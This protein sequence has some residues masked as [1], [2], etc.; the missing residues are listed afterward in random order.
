MTAAQALRAAAGVVA[1]APDAADPAREARLLLCW[2]AGW[3]AAATSAR[4]EEPLPEAAAAR[5]A[6]GAARRAAGA[7]LSHVTG[8][9]AFWEAS[10]RVTPDVLDP[11]PETETLVAWALEGA[12]ARRVLDLGVGSGCILLSLLAAWPSA[13]GVGV[14]A[15]RAA[16]GVAAG[17]AAALGLRGRATLR[18]G[19]WGAGLAGGYDLIVSNPP[20]LTAAETA[21]RRGGVAWE[22]ALALDGGPDGLAPY[23]RIAGAAAGLLAPGGRVLLEHGPD[24]ADAVAALLRGAGL[25]SPSTRRDLDGRPRVTGAH[26]LLSARR[27]AV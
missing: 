12:P 17:N 18:R 2:A 19:D 7:P 5:L 26:L 4:M 3:S 27:A 24:Q 23:R 14:D 11:R 20:Y 1:A 22:P 8:T 13:R 6:A 10:F 16:L 21:A 15:S 9:R 25:S